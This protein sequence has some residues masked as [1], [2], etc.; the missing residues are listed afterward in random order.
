MNSSKRGFV[1]SASNVNVVDY[2]HSSKHNKNKN[3]NKLG[4]GSKLELKEEI[5]NKSSF[6]GIFFKFQNIYF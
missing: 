6:K 4:K 2:D 1:P 5:F 3:K